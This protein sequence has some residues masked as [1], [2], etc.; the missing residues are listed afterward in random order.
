MTEEDQCKI[1]K[2]VV[3]KGKEVICKHC[4]YNPEK[5]SRSMTNGS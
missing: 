2:V 1:C 4:R 5:K 3:K